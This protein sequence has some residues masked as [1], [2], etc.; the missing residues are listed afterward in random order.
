[1]RRNS[2]GSVKK[3]RACLLSEIPENPLCDWLFNPRHR[4]LQLMVMPY[5]DC[6]ANRRQQVVEQSWLLKRNFCLSRDSFSQLV[7]RMY[8]PRI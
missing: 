3:L 2:P 5:G 4:Q 8:K 7:K 6:A 1:V